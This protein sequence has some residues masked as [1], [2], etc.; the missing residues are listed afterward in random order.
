MYRHDPQLTGR[1]Q[2]RG[3]SKG[4][5]LDTLKYNKYLPA[6]ISID[7]NENIYI[8]FS[9]GESDIYSFNL[10]QHS[11]NWKLKLPTNT[12]K[13]PTTP[14][15]VE[16][17]S[18]LYTSTRLYS[19]SDSGS[20][21]WQVLPHKEVGGGYNVQVDRSGNVYYI[22]Q[23]GTTTAA[24]LY[25]VSPAGQLQWSFTD[26]RLLYGICAPAFSPDGNTL[27]LQGGTN[28]TSIIAYDISTQ[29]IKW[30]FGG[31]SLFSTPIVDNQGNIYFQK[32]TV[33]TS[34]D[35]FYC[36][37]KDGDLRWKYVFNKKDQNAH[38]YFYEPTIDHDGNVYI[39]ATKD[40]LVS[41]TNDGLE[42]WKLPLNAYG[43]C[44]YSMVCDRNDNIY[45]ITGNHILLSVS[46]TGNI[47]W[48]IQFNH[49]FDVYPC[50]SLLE[51]KLL[52]VASYNGFIYIIE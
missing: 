42:R 40:T 15:I 50:M 22:E 52:L 16:N 39:L 23:A 26:E 4:I 6:G 19:I 21:L 10:K 34:L 17:G 36:L 44:Y 28:T 18:L 5:I 33:A 43:G 7:A 2:Y 25:C 20:L 8:P 9:S 3:P 29:N 49:G 38:Q 51:G 45:F 24:T 11:L 13:I 14:S 31:L 30:T 32:N 47:Q 37:T 46:K 1:S 41:L 48:S 27:Y 12:L 35:T